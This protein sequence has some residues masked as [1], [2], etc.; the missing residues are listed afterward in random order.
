VTSLERR[1]DALV[2]G[3]E[4][5]PFS[6]LG[7]HRSDGA[8]VV[9]AF[10]PRAEALDLVDA[11]SGDVV[12]AF[13]RVH[14]EG[15]FALRLAASEP[16]A[17]RLRERGAGGV[18]EI[19]DPYRFAPLLGEIDAWLLA[20][21]RHLRLYDVLGAH[22]R[23]IDGVRGAGFAVWAPNARRVSVVGDF[24]G[25]D[26]R[27]HA[28]RLRK[29]CGVWEI[30][31]PGELAGARYKYEIA[32]PG[33]A[34]LPLRSDP[35][36]FAS[37]LRPANASIV[38][39]PSPFAWSDEAWL[40]ARAGASAKA[41][42][43]SIYEVHLGSWKRAGAR[44]E[45]ML[46]YRTLAD[47]L[48]PYARK[49]G[50]THLELLPVMEHPFDG[51]WGYQTTGQF[52]PT[53]RH[54][55]P[56]DF[57]AFVD[58]AHAE[59]IGVILDW[60]PAHFPTDAHGLGNFDGTHLYEH[61]DPRKG[62]HYEWGTYVYNLGRREVANFLVAS[63][64][65]WLRE[66]HVDGLRV[67]AVSS[68]LY[69]DYGREDGQW[70]ANE[71]G[72]NENLEATAFLRAFNTIVHDE[73]PRA[74][75]AA[76]EASA[77]PKVSAPVA[78][79]GLGFDF[80]WNMGWMHDTLRLFKRDPIARSHHWNELTFSLVYAFD[81]HYI[82]PFSHD[83]V[84]HLKRSL[85]GRMPGNDD[86]RFAALRLL[87][88]YMF[89][90]PGKKLLFMGAEFAQEGEWSEARSLDWHLLADPRRQGI[91]ALVHDLNALYADVDALHA[92]DDSW[93]GFEW[94]EADDASRSVAAYLRKDPASGS[95]VVVVLNLSGIAYEGYRVGV[96]LA[97]TYR[98][99]LNTDSATYGG[100]D[101]GNLGEVESSAE[102][103]NGRPFALE[104]YLPPQ[105]ALLLE[106]A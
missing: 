106:P 66:Y 3:D 83:E 94:I 88:A 47:E 74:L 102:G 41:G 57:R 87:Y 39:P 91:S 59:G 95:F 27:V 28:M 25:W 82:L 33:G 2:R 44:G 56:D 51:S 29:E 24:N 32:G 53:S 21:G 105:S 38:V 8:L 9:R 17:Y 104:L 97:G 99:L 35:L 92:C 70:I 16:F 71:R 69:L 12:A 61:A 31:I 1:I 73:V 46:S 18:R 19:D 86:A 52:A 4:R 62:F 90:H 36:A 43:L 72:D 68:L 85:L 22:I 14:P 100:A 65:F 42:P 76:E 11:R 96:P 5:D 64:L 75:T 58:R 93:D 10:R 84:V 6:L 63:A 26:G 34:L 80:K 48:I 7:M 60:V 15:V 77:W 55:A 20:E 103:A 78:D 13:E 37:E 81:E 49:L 79:G 50:F 89:T 45:R 40:A 98:E 101:R 67:D 23:T 54:G 30:F